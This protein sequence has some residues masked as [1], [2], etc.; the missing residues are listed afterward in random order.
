MC[1]VL[2]P[3]FFDIMFSP[4][5]WLCEMVFMLEIMSRPPA[6]LLRHDRTIFPCWANC[7]SRSHNV[8]VIIVISACYISTFV[9][10]LYVISLVIGVLVRDTGWFIIEAYWGIPCYM[11]GLC[12]CDILR[13]GDLSGLMTDVGRRAVL[14]VMLDRVAHNNDYIDIEATHTPGPTLG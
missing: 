14:W 5:I 8:S 2:L 11:I 3:C 7:L 1:L 13:Y 4:F 9:H 12:F 10:L 6:Q